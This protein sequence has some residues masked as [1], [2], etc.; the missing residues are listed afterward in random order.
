MFIIVHIH[1]FF[2][3]YISI[4]IYIYIFYFFILSFVVWLPHHDREVW[5]DLSVPLWT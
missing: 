5:R 1:I 2:Y 4:Y 3:I